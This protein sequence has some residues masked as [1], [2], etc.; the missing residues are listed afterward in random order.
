MISLT[1]VAVQQTSS[2]YSTRLID[3]FKQRNPDFWILLIIYLVSII[4]QLAILTNLNNDI[5]SK[6]HIFFAFFSGLFSF[7]ALAPYMLNTI[8]LLKPLTMMKFLLEEITKNNILLI[9]PDSLCLKLSLYNP[10]LYRQK[11]NT[12]RD[13]VLPIVDIII[14][15]LVKHDSDTSRDGLLRI[16]SSSLQLLSSCSC[17]E[18]FNNIYELFSKHFFNIGKLAITNGDDICADL[19]IN[20]FYE[21]A[22]IF[23]E[24]QRDFET[25]LP[26]D[27][28][29]DI[30]LIA[31]EQRNERI[32]VSTI[33]HFQSFLDQLLDFNLNITH[34]TLAISLIEIGESCAEYKVKSIFSTLLNP[35]SLILYR[36]FTGFYTDITYKEDSEI[37]DS[38]IEDKLI[39]EFYI[40][41]EKKPTDLGF[42]IVKGLC[43][44]GQIMYEKHM[45]ED[46]EDVISYIKVIKNLAPKYGRTDLLN[47]INDFLNSVKEI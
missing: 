21:I 7:I 10:A 23:E 28:I 27:K 47:T 12:I 36:T 11:I 1:L 16:R 46:L 39:Y 43:S 4:Y 42:L 13:P 41:D 5:I 14:S 31:A 38:E 6:G 2:S 35:L 8:D 17:D 29:G 30:G 15:S 34:R 45:S 33:R 37:E 22:I 25:S 44:I 32:V 9:E 18:E 3:I 24:R 19:V 26:L 40:I 20:W